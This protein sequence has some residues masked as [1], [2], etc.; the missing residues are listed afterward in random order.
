MLQLLDRALL[1]LEELRVLDGE[2]GVA[3]QGLRRAQAVGGEGGGALLVVHVDGAEGAGVAP[4]L[5]RLGARRAQGDADDRAQVEGHDARGGAQDGVGE[6]VAGGHDLARLQRP[7]HHRRGDSPPPLREGRALGEGAA[8]AQPQAG[9][10]GVAR[11]F[12]RVVPEEEKAALGS[13]DLH[14]RVQDLLQHLVQDEGR[15]QGLDHG[16]QE[17]VLLDPG[18]LR[19]PGRRGVAPEQREL[20][21][22]VAELDLGARGQLG[23][24][25]LG[26]VD[27]D[28]VEAALVLDEETALL[29]LDVGVGLGDRGLV[30]REVVV[31]GASH[32]VV[33]RA[34][35]ADLVRQVPPR[36]LQHRHRHA[37]P[38]VDAA[39]R[40]QGVVLAAF[41]TDHEGR[42]S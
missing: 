36:D 30:Q 41:G 18:E 39:G 16:E 19:D 1:A 2:G 25:D 29:V 21:R 9:H 34:E 6:G 12:R 35:E 5:V 24:L 38:A 20:E 40:I 27:V 7:L 28:A 3:G 4:A 13:R 15:V 11:A 32:R 22:D 33:A 26:R 42:G 31:A 37:V 23:P 10:R 14:D 8:G 17:L